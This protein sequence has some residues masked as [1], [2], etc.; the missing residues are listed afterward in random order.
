M[1]QGIP[2]SWKCTGYLDSENIYKMRANEIQITP[3]RTKRELTKF[4]KFPWKVY[5]NNPYWVP[6]L[7]FERKRFLN[8]KV[9]PF[10]SHAELVL[11]LAYREEDIVGRIAAV[12][13][14]QFIDY[15]KQD[16][17]YF[18]L[19]ECLPDYSIACALFQKVESWLEERGIKRILGPMNLSTNRECGL[20]IEGFDLS[21]AAM[22]PYNPPYYQEYLERYGFE[23]AMDLYAYFVDFSNYPEEEFRE[24]L[25]EKLS[26]KNFSVRSISLKDPEEIKRIRNV[27][28]S[29]WSENWGFVPLTEQELWYM[30]EEL[31]KVVIPDMALV[32]E[33]DGEIVGFSLTIH[34]INQVLKR[35]N[36]R[37]FPLGIFKWFY[38]KKQIDL[39]RGLTMG[40]TKEC[41]HTGVEV[42]LY[43]KIAEISRAKGC[44]RYEIS[45]VLEDNAPLNN[46][47]TKKL[48]AQLYKKYRIFGKDLR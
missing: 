10:F 20:L 28:N 46:L 6:P 48:N 21:P 34:D 19:F 22:M 23:K 43:F 1:T 7:I 47:L 11:F 40:V 41:R 29:A 44:P 33:K 32:A 8:P 9:N 3:V 18:G 5:K 37:L 2:I 26:R 25:L 42:L 14:S 31:R 16:V 27:Y 30:V 45:W 13:D 24:G 15:Y 17:G 12:I 36:G 38:F 39:L 35:I 4:I